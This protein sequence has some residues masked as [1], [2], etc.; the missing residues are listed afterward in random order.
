MCI[1]LAAYMHCK[2]TATQI[3]KII[4]WGTSKGVIGRFGKVRQPLTILS[5]FFL[6][7]LT[8][9][10]VGGASYSQRQPQKPERAVPEQR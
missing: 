8:P 9:P 7:A 5:Y 10:E 3:K 4:T 2:S 6:S 1:S